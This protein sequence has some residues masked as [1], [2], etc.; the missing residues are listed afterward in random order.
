MESP[1]GA[2]ETQLAFLSPLRG[3]KTFGYCLPTARAVGYILSPLS[4]A[5]S[6]SP[7]RL[8]LIFFLCLCGVSRLSWACGLRGL[9]LA[10]V[11]FAYGELRGVGDA[12]VIG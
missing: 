4:G 5:N 1:G 7:S 3:F 8:C 9:R 10:A 2:K 12:C 6:Y 11:D